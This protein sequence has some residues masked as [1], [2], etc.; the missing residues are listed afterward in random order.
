LGGLLVFPGFC[1]CPVL[2]WGLTLEWDE[3]GLREADTEGVEGELG[4]GIWDV[5]RSMTT[6]WVPTM[7]EEAHKAARA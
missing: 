2:T 7:G 5:R 3:S 1:P 4:T 6:F